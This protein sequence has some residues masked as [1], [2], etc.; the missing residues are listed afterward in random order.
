MDQERREPKTVGHGFVM[1][2]LPPR[3]LPFSPA[4]ASPHTPPSKKNE[5]R[6]ESSPSTTPS[7]KRGSDGSGILP[8]QE[9]TTFH[10]KLK[11][12]LWDHCNACEKWED[13]V[14]LQGAKHIASI[15][16]LS[17]TLDD[18]LTRQFKK[19][20]VNDIAGLY[21]HKGEEESRRLDEM[22]TIL[23]GLELERVEL[24]DVMNKVTKVTSKLEGLSDA[25]EGILIEATRVKGSGFSFEKEMWVTWSMDRFGE[26]TR[27][28]L[29]MTNV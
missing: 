13:V 27:R 24:Q 2:I 15:A 28:C 20:D 12:I 14:S 29:E 22:S 18:L 6:L 17:S 7:R 26:C 11:S 9:E 16:R 19:E 5:D 25:A 1:P 10:R 21:L 4:G 8:R 3:N 23:K